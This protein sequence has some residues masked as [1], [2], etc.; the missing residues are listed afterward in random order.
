MSQLRAVFSRRLVSRITNAIGIIADRVEAA[1]SRPDVSVEDAAIIDRCRPY[2]MTSDERLLAVIDAV[3]YLCRHGISGS[4]VECGVWKG[5]SSMAAILALSEAGDTE[6]DIYL[7]DTFEGMPPPTERDSSYDGIS[8]KEQ[9][10]STPVGTG[11]WCDS[12]LDE[13]QLNISATGYPSERVHYIKGRVEDTIPNVLP[14]QIAMLRLDT[15]WYESTR[16]ELIHLFP[17]LAHGG[18]IVIDDYGHWRGARAATDEY[19]ES[20]RTS[21]F[22]NRI[23]YTGRIGIKC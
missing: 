19:F 14:R 12:S 1:P 6:R 8:A 20:H 13:V 10:Q 23:D 18:V 4:I 7:Y 15:D 5:G 2:T 9:L 17:L 22:L 3:R 21:M 11:V 16:H